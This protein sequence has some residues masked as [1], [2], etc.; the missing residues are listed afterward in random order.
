MDILMPCTARFK[1]LLGAFWRF[2][3]WDFLPPGWSGASKTSTL[4]IVHR[5]KV[6]FGNGWFEPAGSSCDCPSQIVLTI[7]A[8][9]PGLW[10]L[11]RISLLSKADWRFH[12]GLVL[13]TKVSQL[14]GVGH[15]YY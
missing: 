14:P 9:S 2:G 12:F 3:A 4:S 5:W 1:A 6:I 7:P 10:G 11:Q 15:C 8:V 13:T